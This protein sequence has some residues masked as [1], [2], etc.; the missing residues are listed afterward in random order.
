MLRRNIPNRLGYTV[1]D[2]GGGLPGETGGRLRRLLQIGR[3]PGSRRICLNILVGGSPKEGREHRTQVLPPEGLPL[4]RKAAAL[5]LRCG[6]KKGGVYLPIL[7]QGGFLTKLA[8]ISGP[9]V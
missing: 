9:L 3:T 1:R 2:S 7:R 5:F 4:N 6:L 8:P